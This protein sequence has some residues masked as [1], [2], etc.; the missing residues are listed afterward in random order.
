MNS[1][2]ISVTLTEKAYNN[3]V[4]VAKA[5]SRKPAAMAALIL[6]NK[7]NEKAKEL[8]EGK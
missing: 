8:E 1:K 6:S 4:T 2:R 3:L 7:V 5:D